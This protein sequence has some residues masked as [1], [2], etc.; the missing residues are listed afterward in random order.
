VLLY[1]AL[2][3]LP[4]LP[5]GA[6]AFAWWRHSSRRAAVKPEQA[7]VKPEQAGVKPEQAGVKPEQAG[8]EPEQVLAT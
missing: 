5:L 8:A 3:Y 1:R 7:G 6:L 2:T 4:S